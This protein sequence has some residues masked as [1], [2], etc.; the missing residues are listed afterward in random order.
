[1]VGCFT[2]GMHETQHRRA[3]SQLFVVVVDRDPLRH[4][5]RQ[6]HHHQLTHRLHHLPHQRPHH[7]YQHRRL[8]LHLPHRHLWQ[9]R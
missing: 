9:R 2:D 4:Q 3:H 1:M 5:P 8:H 7:R 6:R